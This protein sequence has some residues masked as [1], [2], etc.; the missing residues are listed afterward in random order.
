MF[1]QVLLSWPEINQKTSQ[2]KFG[3]SDKRMAPNGTAFNAVHWMK[4]NGAALNG[5]AV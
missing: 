2:T 1:V 5:I 3:G 4:L